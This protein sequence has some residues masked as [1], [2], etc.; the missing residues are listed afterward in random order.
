MPSALHT[1]KVK[2]ILAGICALLLTIGLARFAYTPLLPIMREEA[3]L[4]LM[5]G[6]W[7]A[8]FNYMGYMSGALLAATT[9]SLTRKF[10]FYR[11]GLVMGLLST[12]AM[13]LTTD[14]VAWAILRYL[15]GLSGASG[16]LLASGLIMNWLLRHQ[17][18]TELG[19]HFSGLGLG[20]VLSGIA[21]GGMSS[22]SIEWNL[23]WNLLGLL[24]LALLVPAWGWMPKPAPLS[25]KTSDEAGEPPSRTWMTMLIAAYF[26]AG[27]GFAISA[28]FIVSIL[29]QLP[30][31]ADHGGWVWVIV[32]LAAS[33]SAFL[34]DRIARRRGM[35]SALVLAFALHAVASATPLLTQE[36]L[37]SLM[38]AALFGGTF[39]GIVSLTLTLVG[40]RY[41]A[42]PS[43][44]MAK[45]TLSYGLAQIVAPAMAGL[46]AEGT[47]SY[48]A[49][50]LVA[51]ILMLVGMLILLFLRRLENQQL[52]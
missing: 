39:V 31:L 21:V 17:Q 46:I 23:Q 16:M 45:L 22:L 26:C 18:R 35:N 11:V 20:I 30:M 6:G 29:I 48:L 28:T 15:A 40:R 34:W 7:L 3:G 2:A 47:G 4:S 32:G 37:L 43:K 9:S 24:C 50:L 1:T 8:T 38:S 33:P 14:P 10:L 41:P 52:A 36:P 44:A 13:G 49:S 27:F 19:L 25:Q 5:G 42:N 51:A 12:A